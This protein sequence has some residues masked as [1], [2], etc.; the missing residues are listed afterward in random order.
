MGCLHVTCD[1][2]KACDVLI[3]HWPNTCTKGNLQMED[4]RLF[5]WTVRFVKNK[6]I[7]SRCIGRTYAHT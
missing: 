5:G 4:H 3:V 6:V 2:H 7:C 1:L